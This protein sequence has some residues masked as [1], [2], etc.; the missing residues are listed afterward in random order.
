LKATL[1]SKILH[2]VS[3]VGKQKKYKPKKEM[4]YELMEPGKKEKHAFPGLME[5]PTL[6][7]ASGIHL[8]IEQPKQVE[9]EPVKRKVGRPKKSEQ[10]VEKSEQV[11]EAKGAKKVRKVI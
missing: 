2:D 6:P 9:S 3:T 7:H 4:P 10:P 11:Q 5:R 8:H 1:T